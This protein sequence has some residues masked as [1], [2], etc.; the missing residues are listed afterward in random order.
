MNLLDTIKLPSNFSLI[1]AK[2]P[3]SNYNPI[4]ETIQ[5][6]DTRKLRNLSARG[7]PD[8]YKNKLIER[9]RSLSALKRFQQ[10]PASS[11]SKLTI[12]R[13]PKDKRNILPPKSNRPAYYRQETD[14]PSLQLPPIGRP[15]GMPSLKYHY[16]ER[17]QGSRVLPLSNQSSGGNSIDS[18][19]MYKRRADIASRQRIQQQLINKAFGLPITPISRQ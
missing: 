15:A 19:R 6:E 3:T 1:N 8:Q 10:K 16:R 9:E 17:S 13:I 14:R 2:L 7:R 4:Y 5:P 18:A 12:S 11:N